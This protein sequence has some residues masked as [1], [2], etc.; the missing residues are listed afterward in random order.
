MGGGRST[1]A[2]AA[3]VSGAGGLGFLAAGYKDADAVRADVAAVR[4]SHGAPVRHQPLRTPA[5]RPRPRRGR[6]QVRAAGSGPR[7]GG[8]PR[9]DD[10]GWEEKLALVADLRVPVVS[11]VFGCPTRSE[12]RRL[13]HAGI[14]V[15]P[16]VTTPD[17]AIMCCGGAGAD[18]LVVQG[19]EAGGHRATF[20]DAQPVDLGLLAAL[21]L[22]AAALARD[23]GTTTAGLGHDDLRG[24][25]DRGGPAALPIIAAGGIATGRGVAAVLAAGAIAAQLGTAFMRC[26]ESATAPVHREALTTATDGADARVHRAHRPRHRQRLHARPRRRRAARLSRRPPRHGAAPRGRPRAR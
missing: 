16:T 17:E 25:D 13:H 24:A 21:Q 6:S 12:V 3:A 1:P 14:A 4:A 10:D 20:D 8:A 2:L 9:H 26:P 11:I 15:W 18:A 7:R 19:A 23:G 5:A 22:I